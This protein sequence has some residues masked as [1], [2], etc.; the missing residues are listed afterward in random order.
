MPS[1]TINN[2]QTAWSI[3]PR[4]NRLYVGFGHGPNFAMAF[5]LDNGTTGTM[6]WRWDAVG[7][8]ESLAMNSAGTQLF[9]GGH[10]GTASLQQHVCGST[11]WLRG[12]V[13]LSLVTGQPVCSPFWLPQLEPHGANYTGAWTMLSTD[14]AL[15]VGGYFT[16]ISGVPVHNVARFTY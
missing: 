13:S 16:S 14:T 12:L 15:W 9:A 3:L 11:P 8:I 2:P 10:F 1:G 4:G 7:N 5:R 6:V